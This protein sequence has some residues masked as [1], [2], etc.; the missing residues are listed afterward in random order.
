MRRPSEGEGRAS[1]APGVRQT[2]K[3]AGRRERSR[4]EQPRT[5]AGRSASS[6]QHRQRG[7]ARSEV[8]G[9][10]AERGKRRSTAARRSSAARGNTARST[11]RAQFSASARQARVQNKPGMNKP[12]KSVNT[13]KR[14]NTSKRASTTSA[15]EQRRAQRFVVMSVVVIVVMI[16]LVVG[17]KF[18]VGKVQEHKQTSLAR[19]D[20][21]SQFLPVECSTENLTMNA[22]TDGGAAG[23]PVSFAVS[24]K[25]TSTTNPCYVDVGWTNLRATI[26]SGGAQVADLAACAAKPK[27]QRWLLD[28]GMSETLTVTWNGALAGTGCPSAS[29]SNVRY[30]QP[31]SYVA[32]ISFKDEAATG[33]DVSFALTSGS[34][35]ASASNEQGTTRDSQGAQA[36]QGSTQGAQGSSQGAQGSA[37]ATQQDAQQG[38]K[39]TTRQGSQQTQQK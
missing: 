21:A 20:P 9:S 13:L 19:V 1:D 4:D 14:A 24:L 37:Q 35:Q 28:R 32:H 3:D 17:G 36:S 30:G 18:A 26:T 23:S 7:A 39:Q 12:A 38:D 15:S 34:A 10:T 16:V 5:R 11:M 6:N 33:V 25:N 31:G 8:R 22:T 27:E 29:G 2:A